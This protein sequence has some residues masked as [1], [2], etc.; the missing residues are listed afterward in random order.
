MNITQSFIKATGKSTLILSALALT[1]ISAIAAIKY[2]NANFSG[3]YTLNEGKSTLGQFGARM[4]A[5]K[6]KVDGQAE[7]MTVTR[8][9]TGQNGDNTTTEKLTFDGKPS[10]ST[11]FGNNKK[12]STAKWS[13][14][15][16]TLTVNSSMTFER[17]GEKMEFKATEVWKLAEDGKTLTIETTSTSSRGTNTTKLVYDKAT[18]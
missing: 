8:T 12:Y 3:D 5:K 4:S 6:L 7:S 15:G 1:T 14:D 11:V 10:E 16:Q 17:N 13:E 9:I 18:K 2:A